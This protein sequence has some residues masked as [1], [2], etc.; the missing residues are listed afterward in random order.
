VKREATV[1]HP[2]DDRHGEA[3]VA[4]TKR[5]TAGETTPHLARQMI[6][7]TLSPPWVG[8]ADKP[9][10]RQVVM[11]Y[12]TV[13]EC[14]RSHHDALAAAKVTYSEARPK[15]IIDRLETSARVN[16]M[17]ASAIQVDAA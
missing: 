14:G 1:I 12:R 10:S 3:T 11:A 4:L 7:R 16:E 13:R 17:I 5:S 2:E 8:E 6:E 9:P 15:A